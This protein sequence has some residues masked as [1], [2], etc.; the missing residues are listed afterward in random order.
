[1]TSFIITN[2]EA[3]LTGRT[4]DDARTDGNLR[5]V[6]GKIDAI[7]DVQP[8]PGE[9]VIDARDAVVTPGLVNTHHHLFQSVLKAVPA[10]VNAALAEW[11]RVVPYSYWQ[12]IDEPTLRT[13]ARVGLAE[14]ALSGAT[15]VA[16]HH[17]F[18]AD[19]YD[20]DPADV[21]FET[22]GEIGVR[23]VLGRGGATK[24]R[25]F[26]TPEIVPF[27][28]EPLGHML[29]GLAT[30]AARWH[31]PQP[32]S[33]RRVAFAPSSPTFALATGELREAAAAT[34]AL[35]LRIHT[36]LSEN[37]DYTDYTAAHFGQ[38]PMPWLAEHD[39]LG[40]D[41]WFAHLVECDADEVGI[42]AETGAAMAHCPQSNMRLA[43]GIAPADLL[44]AR[45]GTVS[46]GVDG[47]A[48][49]EAADM[50]GAMY[51]AFH[52]HRATKGPRATTAE[53]V[54]HWASAGGAK[55]L[56]LDMVGTLEPGKSADIAIFDLSS[57]RHLGFHDRALAPVISGTGTVRHSF[58]AG[59][60]LVTDGRVP[61]LDL[62]ELAHDARCAVDHLA[63]AVQAGATA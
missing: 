44:H 31:D 3:I 8:V 32:D 13:A 28:T 14:L 55:A 6:D 45:G 54:L 10:G 42:L 15:T 2:A 48:S 18:F 29:D 37:H 23:F 1:M 11:L 60:P 36:H 22:A 63:T 12:H 41:V 25:T 34:R 51:M 9:T 5:V 49:N 53:T 56:G 24:T 61:G 4:G 57:P 46:L 19:R 21:L 16:D 27:P 47:A 58:V 43:S 39:W 35:G 62:T 52:L 38:R 50:T 33:M 30:T 40:P 59:R 26:D 17:Y 20:Y 7:G